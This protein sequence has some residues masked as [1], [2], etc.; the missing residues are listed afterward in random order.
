MAPEYDLKCN[1]AEIGRDIYILSLIVLTAVGC[2]QKVDGFITANQYCMLQIQCHLSP[3]VDRCNESGL[4]LVIS[5]IFCSLQ[6][7]NI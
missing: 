3:R 1:Y 5:S 6:F 4:Y 7:A 2:V